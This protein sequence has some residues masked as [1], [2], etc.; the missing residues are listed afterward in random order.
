MEKNTTYTFSVDDFAFTD[1]ENDALVSV[2]IDTLPAAGTL[3]LSG[4]PVTASQP[5]SA[6]DIANLTFT[7]VTDATGTSY[8]SIGY[9]VNDGTDSS[10]DTANIQL[11]V[12]EPLPGPAYQLSLANEDISLNLL[13]PNRLNGK[14]Y[15]LLDANGDNQITD[16][17]RLNQQAVNDFMASGTSI[18]FDNADIVLAEESDITHLNLGFNDGEAHFWGLD[19]ATNT[20]I[21]YTHEGALP[22]PDYSDHGYLVY[23]LIS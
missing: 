12:N 7:P 20:A 3:S 8:A 14:Y 11:D 4:N 1:I 23:Q 13:E 21:L 2:T 22:Y 15:Y 18:H 17:D 10:L 16:D 5:I 9:R 19:S 6:A